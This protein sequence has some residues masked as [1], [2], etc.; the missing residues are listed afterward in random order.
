MRLSF[1]PAVP[2]A[3]ALLAGL[4][5]L[6]PASAGLVN[7]WSFNEAAGNATDG[8][9]L[10]DSISGSVATVRGVDGTF[11]GTTLILPGTTTGAATPASMAAYVDLPNGLISSKTN[12]TVEVWATPLSAKNWMRVFDFGRVNTAGVGGGAPGE[13]TGTGTA[14]SGGT[15][16]SDNLMLSFCRGTNLDQQ[17]ME[18]L[19]NGGSKTTVDSGIATATGTRYHYVMTFEDGVGVYGS[20]GGQVTWYRD[21]LVIGTGAVPFHL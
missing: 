15:S 9:T 6:P 1:P 18:T 7:R 17:R 21:G 8:L 3:F 5:F 16:A 2:A 14:G 11:S 20:G 13:I 4:L 10:V 12:L 19:L